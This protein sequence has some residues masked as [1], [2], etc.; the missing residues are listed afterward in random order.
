MKQ[1]TLGV[2]PMTWDESRVN[3]WLSTLYFQL[4]YDHHGSEL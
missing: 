1:K 4:S 2:A 3:S